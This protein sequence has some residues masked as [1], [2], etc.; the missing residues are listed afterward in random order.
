MATSDRPLYLPAGLRQ[1]LLAFETAGLLDSVETHEVGVA[2][3]QQLI[4][5]NPPSSQEKTP[6]LVQQRGL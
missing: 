6:L 5:V 3:M 2:L 4:F 1:Q